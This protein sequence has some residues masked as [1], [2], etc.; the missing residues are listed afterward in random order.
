[1]S[2]R[3]IAILN[4]QQ[5]ELQSMD[6]SIEVDSKQDKLDLDKLVQLMKEKLKLSHKREK[7]KILTL[8]TESWSLQKTAEKFKVS[9]ATARKARILREEKGILV[10]P[11]P[12]IEKRLSEKTVNSVLEF[13]Q[14]ATW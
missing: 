13:Y 14:K 11:Q 4:V 7:I 5:S 1:M 9:K 12:A 8:T 2:K 3:L 6:N 10:V